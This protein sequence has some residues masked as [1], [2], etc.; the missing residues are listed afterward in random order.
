MLYPS[1]Y[2]NYIKADNLQNPKNAFSIDLLLQGGVKPLISTTSYAQMQTDAKWIFT[3][4]DFAHILL[5]GQFGYTVVKNLPS[6]PLSLQF[7]AGG[8]NSI[9]GFPDSG[10]GPGKYLT[11]GSIEYQNHIAGNYYGALFYDA[12][13]ATN[14][15]NSRINQGTGIGVLYDTTVGPIKLYVARAVSHRGKPFSVEFSFGPDFS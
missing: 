6:F 11:V 7:L 5:R 4:V 1:W 9:R 15:F 12:G 2:I 10:L 14:H 13:Y 3:P 8:V